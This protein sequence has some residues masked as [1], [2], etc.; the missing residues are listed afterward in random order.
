MLIG[1]GTLML[2]LMF[3]LATPPVADPIKR[4][5]LVVAIPASEN[6]LILRPPPPFFLFGGVLSPTIYFPD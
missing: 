6:A 2:D 3:E 4:P 5:L 1:I